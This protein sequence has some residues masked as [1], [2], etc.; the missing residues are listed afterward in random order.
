MI[1]QLTDFQGEIVIANATVSPANENVLWFMNK[2]EPKFLNALF[3]ETF[4]ALFTAGIAVT[5]PV[6]AR[7]TA[8]L[9]IP[10]FTMA[11]DNYIYYWYMRDQDVQTFGTGSGKSKN[12]NS[13]IASARDKV[14]RAWYEMYVT[15]WQILKFLNDNATTYPEYCLPRWYPIFRLTWGNDFWNWSNDIFASPFWFGWYQ[16]YKLPDIF[17]PLSRL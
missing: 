10:G 12:T 9:N 14:S 2:Y 5:P 11:I 4:A 8:I 7:W 15:N 6:D 17:V 16:L 1:T 13:V 3:G